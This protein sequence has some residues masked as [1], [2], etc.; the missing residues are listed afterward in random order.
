MLNL[1]HT[2]DELRIIQMNLYLKAIVIAIKLKQ[3]LPD[4]LPRCV[5]T[6]IKA[7]N[8]VIKSP[9]TQNL[10]RDNL[11]KSEREARLSLQIRI[12][13]LSLKLIKKALW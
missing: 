8:Y 13:L 12:T 5:E 1:K 11:T 7:V 10:L 9:K 6:F 3:Y 2:L 4:K